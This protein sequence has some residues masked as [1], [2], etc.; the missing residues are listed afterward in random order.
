MVGQGLL[1]PFYLAHWMG[2]MARGSHLDWYP[3]ASL[4]ISRSIFLLINIF[5]GHFTRLMF[6]KHLFHARQC[7][8][9]TKMRYNSP[10]HFPHGAYRLLEE[11]AMNQTITT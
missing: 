5:L 4:R 10:I 9:N 6:T 11:M 7:V 2:W 1:G 8:E 3:L